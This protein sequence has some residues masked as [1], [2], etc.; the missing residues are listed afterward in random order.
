M[1]VM[2]D[3]RLTTP[4]SAREGRLKP[5]STHTLIDVIQLTRRLR[6]KITRE[7]NR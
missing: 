3:A 2:C 1:V 4:V 6:I 7:N 5:S